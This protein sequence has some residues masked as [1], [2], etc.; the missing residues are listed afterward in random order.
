VPF[1][2]DGL[3]PA[4]EMAGEKCFGQRGECSQRIDLLQVGCRWS[5]P[6]QQLVSVPAARRT[7]DGELLATFSVSTWTHHLGDVTDRSTKQLSNGWFS[8][9]PSL[10]ASS[11]SDSVVAYFD[12]ITD[13][14]AQEK[15][16]KQRKLQ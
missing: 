14:A 15:I 13:G 10:S 1:G 5:S 6:G 9:F 7:P 12:V 4:A 8:S 3:G 16:R 2:A 11:Q